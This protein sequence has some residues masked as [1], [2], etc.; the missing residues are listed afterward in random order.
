MRFA[1]FDLETYIRTKNL[2]GGAVYTI[3]EEELPEI[4]MITDENGNP[5]RGGMIGYALAYAMM[6]GFVGA[7]FYIL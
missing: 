5:T 3:V 7:M 2:S 4:E 1:K 6:A